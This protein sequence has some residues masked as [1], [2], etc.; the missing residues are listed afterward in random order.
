MAFQQVLAEK[1]Y[2]EGPI[3]EADFS[4]ESGYQAVK[5]YLK[6]NPHVPDALLQLMM[7]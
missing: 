7:H 6:T 2:D 3:I 5:Q 4:V 1:G